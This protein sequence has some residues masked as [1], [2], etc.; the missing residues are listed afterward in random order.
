M[1]QAMTAASPSPPRPAGAAPAERTPAA[2]ALHFE[3]FAILP[4]ER[5]L[6]VAGESV[7]IG[8]R[9]FDLLLALVAARDRV[10]RKD[11]LLERVWPGLV[12][13]ENNLSV[14]VSQL[15]KLCG[16]QV[17]STV[18]GRGYQFTATSV[19]AS[20]AR[21]QPAPHEDRD[22]D[23][24]A[25]AAGA[26]PRGNLPAELPPLIGREA[27]LQELREMLQAHRWITITGAGGMGKTRLAEQAG[28][29]AATHMPAWMVELA[30]V[31]DVRFVPS[32]V[33]QVL[34]ATIVDTER[35]LDAIVAALQDQPALLILDN[36]EHLIA[37]VSGLCSQ[38][39]R[40]LPLLRVL[41]TSQEL[42]RGA[43]EVVYKLG[44]LTLPDP[45]NLAGATQVGS[46]RL[47]RAR[48]QA[49]SRQF[50]ITPAN[51][52]DAAV[53]CQQ[54]DGLPLAIELAA[55][56]VPMLGLDGVRARLGE[57]FRLLTGDARVRLRRHQTLRA[58]LDWSY[59]LLTPAEQALLRR[60]GVFAG[61]FSVEGARQIAGDLGAD[62]W[63]VLDTLGSLIDKSLV[64]VRGLSSPRYQ[65]LETAR[66]Y[67]LEQ[68]A[69]N[70]ETGDA[71]AR[72][73]RATRQVCLL[74][75]RRRDTQAIWDEIPNIR[76]AFSW[77]MRSGDTE[78]AVGLVN[79]SS[80][81]LALGGMVG[82]VVQRLV[83]VEPCVNERLPR[84]LAAQYWQ[85]LGRFGN[86]GRLPAHRC[87]AALQAAEGLFRELANDR[88]VH[89]C[90][91][92]RA[93]ALVE[94]GSLDAAAQAIDCA[95]QLEKP[96]SPLADRMRRLRIEAKL[97]EARGDFTPA[98]ERL[99]QALDMARLADIHRYVA[100][101]TQDIGQ[102]L[103][104]A[105]D[106]AAAEQRFRAVL[107]DSRPD[108]SVALA[109]AYARMGLAT[110]LL[111]Q[112][113]LGPAR[114]AALEAIPR[115][116]SCG[117]LLAHSEVFAWLL[118][119]LG[120]AHS[121][122]VLLGTADSFRAFSQTTR[123]PT[124]ARACQA[125]RKLLGP[126]AKPPEQAALVAI[127]S[128]AELAQVLAS[129]LAMQADAGATGD[130]SAGG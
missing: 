109:V 28:L 111:A 125:A 71:L 121:A 88:H 39:L 101:L 127:G 40:E 15:R 48:V 1:N 87:V 119:A 51:V 30:A 62:E 100:T 78:L 85:W 99:Q 118:A 103:L 96:G 2:D 72:H 64:Q 130:A 6:L 47:L 17:I 92:M 93:E 36:C 53:I 20:R 5:R 106:A 22:D 80:V 31:S 54:L 117:I 8:A 45:L 42:L 34:G 97:L 107:G 11:E 122:T 10:V 61:T 70:D 18:P 73:A 77:A 104:H 65:M 95:R 56:R 110:A 124:Q 23:V 59:H 24:L 60:L 52:G 14:H 74:A 91:R 102:C 16:P 112:G 43:D 129:A 46:V 81:V 94:Q 63:D 68:L 120:Q 123:G 69:A 98:L 25:G 126:A 44:P 90:L 116:R 33:A 108:L 29:E 115:L 113:R 75:T 58:A 86:D 12:V 66:A 49:L 32:A 50:E 114:A 67:A 19:D 82:E 7:K 9:A 57:L 83:E 38:L 128:D 13:E 26:M 37:A 35:P 84:P 3:G 41:V 21:Q 27:E 105:G 4:A 76:A 89:A 79:D 55:G